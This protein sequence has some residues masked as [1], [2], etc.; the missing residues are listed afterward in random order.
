MIDTIKSCTGCNACYN[1]CPRDCIHMEEDI[2][3]KYPR[4]TMTSV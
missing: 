3:A 1:I 4:L 2:L